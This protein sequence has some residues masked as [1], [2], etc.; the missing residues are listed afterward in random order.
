MKKGFF[1]SCQ[2][3]KRQT[4]A[5]QWRKGKAKFCSRSCLAK[6]LLPKYQVR[7]K[8]S[9]KPFHTYKVF[10]SP[11]GRMIREHRWVMEQYLGR[12]LMSNEHVH[13]IDGN[14]RNNLIQNLV[15][16]SNSEHQKLHNKE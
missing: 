14:S 9:G 11:D 5:P 7:F 4:Y 13:H 8:T 15:V 6:K 3:C 1:Y 2:E 16:L 10:K 12:K